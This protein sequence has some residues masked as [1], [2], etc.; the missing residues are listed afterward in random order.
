M[1]TV[2]TTVSTS[3]LMNSSSLDSLGERLD[4]SETYKNLKISNLA[5]VC[6]CKLG[7][8]AQLLLNSEQL[9][10]LRKTL[11]PVTIFFSV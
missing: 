2:L 4:E 3:F 1:P 10:V 9:V 7:I 8:G 11:R 6:S 5:E